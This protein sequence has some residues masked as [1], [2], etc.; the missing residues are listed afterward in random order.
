MIYIGI[1][2][3][4]RQNGFAVC[5]IDER[6]E[7]GFKIF[8][9]GFLSFSSWLLY[10]VPEDCVIAIENSNEQKA[11]F[12]RYAGKVAS[13]MSVGKNMAASQMTVD[14]CRAKFGNRKVLSVSPQQKGKKRTA[15]E[16]KL[17]ARSLGLKGFPARSNQDQRDAFLM[18]VWALQKSPF[19]F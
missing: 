18:A 5:V 15:T 2:P 12:K 9:D 1:D 16:C 14:L 3:A 10:E 17:I 7:V 6:R 19:R 13:A 11:L 8:K 4:F